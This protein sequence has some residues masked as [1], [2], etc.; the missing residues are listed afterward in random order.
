MG[1]DVFFVIRGF[2]I[3]IVSVSKSGRPYLSMGSFFIKRFARII[4]F[5]WL[6]L[7]IHYILSASFSEVGD[8]ANYARAFFLLPG[9]VRPNEV[10]TLRNEMLFYL[11]FALTFLGSTRRTWILV[12]WC[13]AIMLA[14]SQ[15]VLEHITDHNLW[16]FHYV[17]TNHRNLFFISGVFCGIVF[18]KTPRMK[19]SSYA[20]TISITLF[21]ISCFAYILPFHHDTLLRCFSLSAV[22]AAL[23]LAAALI[24]IEQGGRLHAVASML[25]DASYSIYLAHTMCVSAVLRLLAPT[26]LLPEV[27]VL[28]SAVAAIC[29]G[30]LVHRW[31]EV[32]VVRLAQ[33]IYSASPNTR[34]NMTTQA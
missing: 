13:A 15:T 22:F 29:W 8:G 31:V 25:G 11:L 3:T 28:L 4:P 23:V 27:A 7:I 18:I 17:F 19:F 9:A 1:V 12:V 26:N 5:L 16:D 32:P 20:V 34:T 21:V 6:I 10:W 14:N 2:I 33:R 24:R 30:V